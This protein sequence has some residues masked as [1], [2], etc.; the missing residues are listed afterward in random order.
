MSVD[1]KQNT[2]QAMM[3]IVRLC[4]ALA[5]LA[6]TAS[7][8]LADDV[9]GTWL[10]DNGNVGVKFEPCGDAICG[11]IV[12]LKSGSDSKAKVGQ[13]LFFDMRP[14]GANS[15][16]GKAANPDN[17]SIYSGKMSVEG[18]TLSTSGCIIGGLICKSANWKRVP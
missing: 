13:R 14:D 18:S 8:V 17:G 12:W 3:N 6:L 2:E 16:T 11:N 15:W 5:A 7:S 9:F 10:R 4:L 1:R